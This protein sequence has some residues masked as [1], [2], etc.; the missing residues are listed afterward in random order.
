M[1]KRYKAAWASGAV[2][3]EADAAAEEADALGLSP[4]ETVLPQADRPVTP[5]RTRGDTT[6][7]RRADRRS[8]LVL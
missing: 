6:A 7:V 3:E 2:W 8:A 4:I 1:S 5:V